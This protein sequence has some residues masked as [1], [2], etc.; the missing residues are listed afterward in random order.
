M[1]VKVDYT[2]GSQGSFWALERGRDGDGEGEGD[3]ETDSKCER[4][5]STEREIS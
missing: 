4:E 3:R 2:R 1:G 5:R